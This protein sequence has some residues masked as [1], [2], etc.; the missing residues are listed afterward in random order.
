MPSSVYHPL[1]FFFDNLFVLVTHRCMVVT[2][3]SY[4]CMFQEQQRYFKWILQLSCNWM[5]PRSSRGISLFQP[6]ESKMSTIWSFSSRLAP[7]HFLC[8]LS[9]T[10]RRPL[11]FRSQ[12]RLNRASFAA[13]VWGN[14][15]PKGGAGLAGLA[16][17]EFVFWLSPLDGL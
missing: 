15:V 14:S 6:T 7:F 8:K 4:K 13:S 11:G 3:W 16:E 1:R 10:C 9:G 12:R 5:E 2:N 17:L